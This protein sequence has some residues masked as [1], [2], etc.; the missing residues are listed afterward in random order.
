MR[1]TDGTRYE[2]GEQRMLAMLWEWNKPGFS[3]GIQRL[4]ELTEPKR[5]ST[6][7]WLQLVLGQSRDG[8]QSWEV[9]CF[10]HGLPTRNPGSCLPGVD[11]P[12]CGDTLCSTLRERWDLLWKKYRTPWSERQSMECEVCRAERRRRWCIISQPGHD[13]ADRY[14][15]SVFAEA[16]LVHPFRSPTNH[17]QRLRALRFARE[18]ESRLLW[19]VAYDKVV[20]REKLSQKARSREATAS[21]LTFDDRKTAGIPGFF[22]LVLDLPV[23]FTCEPTHGDRLKG[24]F[25]NAR[26]WLR[27]WELPTAEEQRISQLP[28]AEVAL[29]ERPVALYVEMVN[30]HPDLELISGR[31]IYILR[32]VWKPWYKDGD[33]RQVQI[34]R[35]GF[36]LAPDFGGTAHAYCGFSLDACIG[37]LL[38]W[39]DKPNRETAV[40]GYIINSRIRSADNL[41]IARPYSPSLFRLGPSSR[42][43]L[44]VAGFAGEAHE[45]RSSETM[46][47]RRKEA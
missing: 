13:M 8:C 29:R 36:P 9:Y 38:D 35:C 16:P 44:F 47:C 32:Q 37:D 18:K 28:D 46:G 15:H 12:T 23:R 14:L 4:F 34:S 30:P 1:K 11:Q 25:T 24:V 39:W 42:A 31:R 41:M 7:K 27:G 20:S 22:P 17:A 43:A 33:A 6:D 5:S 21:W 40:R 45:T 10:V 2:A 26:G 19:I 3:N